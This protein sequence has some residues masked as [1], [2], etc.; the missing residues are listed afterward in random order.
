[1]LVRTESDTKA[2]ITVPDPVA[3][4]AVLPILDRKRYAVKEHIA[5]KI[6]VRL[7]RHQNDGIGLLLFILSKFILPC[8]KHH[9]VPVAVMDVDAV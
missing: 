4:V 2:A 1:M 7:A 6:L 3:G 5:R 9:K 8:G